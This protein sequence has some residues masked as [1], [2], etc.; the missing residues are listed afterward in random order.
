V[1]AGQQLQC[2]TV[3]EF[4]GATGYMKCK[5]TD[6]GLSVVVPPALVVDCDTDIL[7]SSFR[8]ILP[9]SMQK[10]A[11]AAVAGTVEQDRGQ[12]ATR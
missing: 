1:T 8:P 12:S 4:D 10:P 3:H 9:E 11:A 7:S 2:P 6:S 5:L